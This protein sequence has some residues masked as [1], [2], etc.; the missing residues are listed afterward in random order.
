[1]SVLHRHETGRVA[2]PEPPGS[3]RWSEERYVTTHLLWLACASFLQAELWEREKKKENSIS[4]TWNEKEEKKGKLSGWLISDRRHQDCTG[5]QGREGGE[6]KGGQWWSNLVASSRFFSECSSLKAYTFCMCFVKLTNY[7][8]LSCIGTQSS[9]SATV[10][11]SPAQCLS[12]TEAEVPWVLNNQII[13]Q[14][15][16]LRHCFIP[17][18]HTVPRYSWTRDESSFAWCELGA[19][20]SR[21]PRE[22]P[23]GVL[24]LACELMPTYQNAHLCFTFPITSKQLA[25]ST[26]TF[27]KIILVKRFFRFWWK[28]SGNRAR[29]SSAPV[30]PRNTTCRVRLCR[31]DTSCGKE[32]GKGLRRAQQHHGGLSLPQGPAAAG[33]PSRPLVPAR[34]PRGWRR[35]RGRRAAPAGWGGRA[36]KRSTPGTA[37]ARR[38]S[39]APVGE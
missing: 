21:K 9:C 26:H 35:W 20:P 16:N 17:T 22:S 30:K 28:F 6:E 31:A 32:E 24:I 13:P 7:Q 12:S 38:P 36:G 4:N 5:D 18:C 29:M 37:A 11:C 14:R 23:L 39:T 33:G 8:A 15:W 34:P 1:M 10:L 3:V 19:R 27:S 2:L 25:L